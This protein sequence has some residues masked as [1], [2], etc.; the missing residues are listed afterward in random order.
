MPPVRRLHAPHVSTLPVLGIVLA[1]GLLA[2]EYSSQAT[3]WAVMTDELQTSKLATSIG[4]TLSPVPRIHG[5][6]YGA[7]NQLYPLL[8]APLY[9]WL[10]AP[11][12][13]DGA[14]VLNAFLLASSAWPAYLLGRSVTRRVA[15][16]YFAAALTAFTPWLV[17]SSTLLTENAAYPAFVWAVF[18]CHRALHEPSAGRDAAAVGALAL[19]YLARTQ[20]FVLALALPIAVV[21][22]ERRRAF[23]RHRLLAA[24]YGV[25]AVVAAGLAAAG[26]L[27]RV[28]GN[29]A[30]TVQGDVFPAGVWHSTAV[31]LDEVVVGT[32]VAPFLLAAA[33]AFTPSR[34]EARAFAVLLVPLVVLITF[35]AASFDL[36]FTPGGFTQD[37]YVCYLAP[38]FAVGAA[39]C[40]LD[41][42]RRILRAG[43][44][45]AAG[46]AFAW[47]AAAEP[48]DQEITLWWASPAGA[49]HRALRDAAS[50]IGLS[51]DDL[52]R[53]G[54]LVLAAA[55]AGAVWR[56]PAR[57]P[58]SVLGV[59]LAVYGAH[60]A[61]YVFDWVAVPATT[62]PQTVEG[63]SRDWIDAAL[64]AGASVAVAPSPELAR[65]Y[66][67]D[68]EFWN[69]T[70]DRTVT[71]GR[72]GAF[73]PFASDELSVDP[74]TGR[75]RGP[76][77]TGLLVV[78]DAAPL[79]RLAGATLAT[80]EP[81]ALV[82]AKRPYRAEWLVTGSEPAGW[83]RPGK[84]VRFRFFSGPNELVVSVRAPFAAQRPQRFVLRSGGIVRA[85]RV[86]PG[87]VVSRRLT[88]CRVATLV[89]RGRV[90]MHLD[91]IVV[92][93]ASGAC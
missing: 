25:C 93:P 39:A 91:R 17:L 2:V 56:L 73:T 86:P 15:G 84:P 87:G 88:A 69:K 71:V 76:E 9:R 6:Y 92:R 70:V 74:R 43:L 61:R 47:L 90:S 49:F 52:V 64:P 34:R 75:V 67:W 26:S 27:S 28:L 16:G 77:P 13:F 4:E 32:G 7:L 35:E 46:L 18:L 85:G 23:A 44:V 31:H 45:L 83:A 36:R 21:A 20:L 60:E 81:L 79:V 48:F 24:A 51:A 1:A 82:R 12:A 11:A 3:Q 55:L 37:R 57:V 41:P 22:L 62:R 5:A 42:G 59:V 54:G 89:A 78:D 33:W 14:H 63:A 68:A 19:A 38:L 40:L 8:L 58:L 10:S 53:Y 65:E 30:G 72:G 50:A 66:W 29:Y 80:A